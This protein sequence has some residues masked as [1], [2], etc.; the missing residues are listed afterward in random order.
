[1]SNNYKSTLQTNNEQLS[2]NNLDLQALIDRANALPDAG[3]SEGIELPTLTN[4]GTSAD[5]LSGK[6]LI[7]DEGQIVEGSFTIDDEINTQI[8]LVS[9]IQ[10]ALQ[11][12]ANPGAGNTEVLIGEAVPEDCMTLT[13]PDSIGKNNV[14]VWFCGDSYYHDI[15]TGGVY[16]KLLTLKIINGVSLNY[17]THHNS[18][19]KYWDDTANQV[20][21]FDSATGTITLPGSFYEQFITNNAYGYITW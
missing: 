17:A 12:K 14:I 4:E 2:S 15:G 16:E 5:L 3:D 8:S 6:Q 10:T 19:Y 11:G 18:N 7:D 1:M 20:V 21:A 9:Q 13:I